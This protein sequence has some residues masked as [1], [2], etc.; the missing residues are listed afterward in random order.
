M[1]RPTRR[2]IF[3]ISWSWDVLVGKNEGNGESARERRVQKRWSA[4][5][6]GVQKVECKGGSLDEVFTWEINMSKTNKNPIL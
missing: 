4:C 1:D 5:K 3:S 6:G 2:P